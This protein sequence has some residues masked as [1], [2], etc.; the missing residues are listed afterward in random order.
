MDDEIDATK[1]FREPLVAQ[2]PIM[3][4]AELEADP[5]GVFRK[6]RKTHS[7]VLHETGGYF[8]LRFSDID[9]LSKDAALRSPETVSQEV[10]SRAWD[11]F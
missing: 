9:R 4:L 8:V 2:L 1:V 3:T 5:H 7:V 11:D 10:G 6:Y